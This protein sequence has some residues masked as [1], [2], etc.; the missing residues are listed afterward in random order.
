VLRKLSTLFV[1]GALVAALV[2]G[3]VAAANKPQPKVKAGA[4]CPKPT[5]KKAAAKQKPAPAKK[6]A[7]KAK[8]APAKQATRQLP[9][10]LDL[11]AK[12]CIPCKM[13]ALVLSDL[14]KE[15]KG[16]LA[17]EFIDTW[18]NPKAAEKY[19]IKTIPTQILFDRKGKEFFRHEGYFPKEDILK[20]FRKHGIKLAG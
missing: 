20:T 2:T 9:K 16:K 4:V 6:A 5:P 15:Y 14:K 8:K 13:M 18:E 17:V 12:K 3:Q 10:L 7:P 19:K 11:G 1:A